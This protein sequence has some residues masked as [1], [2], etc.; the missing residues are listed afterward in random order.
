MAAMLW[1]LF[2]YIYD[3]TVIKLKKVNST[4][5][6]TEYAG[7]YMYEGTGTST[8]LQFFNHPEGYIAPVISTGGEISS[9]NYVYQYKDHL[10]NVRLTYADDPSNPG[11]PTIIEESNYYPFGL[12]HKG[13]NTGGDTALG[14]DVAQRWK[15]N[16]MELD[17]SFNIE[18]YDF[19]ARNYDPALGKWMNLDPLAEQ[20]TRHSP[21]N[22][23][24]DNPVFFID[25]DGMKPT[26]YNVTDEYGNEAVLTEDEL[27]DYIAENGVTDDFE[28]NVDSDCCKTFKEFLQY[29]KS[30]FNIDI[31]DEMS[32]NEDEGHTEL[33]FDMAPQGELKEW[34]IQNKDDLL[35]VAQTAQDVGDTMAV[36]GYVLTVSV[37]GAE[38]GVPL[39]GAGN[40]VSTLGSGLEI[41]VH[42]STK[43]IDNARNEA[44]FVVAGKLIDVALK[45][46]PG[47]S[48]IGN[49]IIDQNAGLKVILV[50]RI[51]ERKD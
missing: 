4:G 7:N 43:D 29:V 9:F 16:G 6:I 21:Y 19:G 37:V 31:Q 51:A 48:T 22:Y 24:F 11:T 34:I 5:T 33:R 41:T 3:A 36:A 26:K 49:Q 10:G 38:V 39:A 8:D 28:D 42:L 1:F 20:M 47:G 13:Y 14:N 2:K 40:I 46:V 50:E 45:K 17:E 15:Y 23:A 32:Q 25:P 44:G 35:V 12:K 30:L 18:T 27:T